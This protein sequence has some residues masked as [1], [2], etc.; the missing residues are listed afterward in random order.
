MWDR[1]VSKTFCIKDVYKNSR[2]KEILKVTFSKIEKSVNLKLQSHE[3]RKKRLPDFE[4]L[5]KNY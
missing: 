4:Y 5:R 2:N 1:E 3:V